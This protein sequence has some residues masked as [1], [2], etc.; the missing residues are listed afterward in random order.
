M[1]FLTKRGHLLEKAVVF[2]CKAW[3]AFK[4]KRL[5]VV[6]CVYS[7]MCGSVSENF[8]QRHPY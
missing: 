6:P 4:V 3:V 8:K 7:Y 2:L 1:A 5:R